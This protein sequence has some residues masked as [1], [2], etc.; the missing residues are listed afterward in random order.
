M[1]LAALFFL[2][3][4]FYSAVGFGG[5]S[6][7]LALLVLWDL[8]YTAIPIIALMCNIVVV[9]GNSVH[10]LRAGYFK[11]R[12]LWP[13][14]VT[15]IP[16]AYLGGR[17]PIGKELFLWLLFLTLLVTGLRLLFTHKCYDD[18]Q[19]DLREFP[20]WLGFVLGAVLGG[21]AGIVGIGGGIFLAPVLYA[22]HAGRPQQI[23]CTASLFILFNSLAG[24]VGQ[25]QKN[26]FGADI[27]DYWYLP[28]AALIGGQLGNMI[29]IKWLPARTLALMTAVL[30]LFV[31]ARLGWRVMAG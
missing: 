13:V 24:L 25:W 28:L 4:V 1:M 18:T 14:L 3:A 5:G 29:T 9:S 19:S 2:V 23:A 17:L 22:L 26:G 12:L 27:A 16:A 11:A 6:S 8:P 7:Y 15:S 20:L 21:L 30:V 31:A 10:Y